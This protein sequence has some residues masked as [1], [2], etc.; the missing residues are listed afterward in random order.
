M[1]LTSLKGLPDMMH[2][3]PECWVPLH[4]YP[5]LRSYFHAGT[6]V[7]FGRASPTIR[8]CVCF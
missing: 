1:V 8:P 6:L 4:E 3:M 7:L 5:A 2:R